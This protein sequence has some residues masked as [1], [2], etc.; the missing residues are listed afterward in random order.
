M[1]KARKLITFILVT[2]MVLSMSMTAW[3]TDITITGGAEG[4]VYSAY[5]LLNATDGGDGK[6]SYTLTEN[7]S[8]KSILQEVTGQTEEDDIIAYIAAQDEPE[9]TRAFADAVYTKIKNVQPAISADFTETAIEEQGVNKATFTG[10]AQGYYLIAEITTGSW[11]ED[12][13]SDTHSLVMLDTAGQENIE[14]A[15]KEER[16][17]LDKKIVADNNSVDGDIAEDKKSNNMSVGSKV[18]YTLTAT[19]PADAAQYDYY[20]CIFSDKLSE[21]LT[22]VNSGSNLLTV[23]A[24]GATEPTYQLYTG[25]DSNDKTRY[26]DG[27][28][29]Q[30]ALTNAK[31]LAGQTVTVT[32]WAELN[33]NAVVGD[34]TG[35]SNT[36]DLTYSNDPNTQYGETQG[37]GTPGKPDSTKNVPTGETPSEITTTYTTGIKILKTDGENSL[38][39]AEF[40]ITGNNVVVTLVS[41]AV[42]TED[43]VNGTYYLLKDGTYTSQAP[44]LNDEYVAAGLGATTG[45]VNTGTEQDPVWVEYDSSNPTHEELVVYIKKEANGDL[46]QS[47]STKYVKSTEFV[48]EGVG[49]SEPEVKAFV[50]ADGILYFEGLGEGTYTITETTVPAGYNKISDLTVTI[51]W[52]ESAPM[53]T[54]TVT[55]AEGN[56]SLNYIEENGVGVIELPIVNQAGSE[57]PST[58]GMGTT[59]FYIVG[60]ALVLIAVVLLITKKRMKSEK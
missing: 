58:G 40:Q 12:S 45:W 9:E 23:T 49:Q 4:S 57:L 59:L 43:D 2:V 11:G 33:E 32:Y 29:F 3:A 25:T 52:N 53:W 5:K 31:E 16:P 56:N 48:K 46:Y 44:Q 20:Y 50:D 1:K 19:I 60:G 8:I 6:F 15:T 7:E 55:P 39:G 47:T 24:S 51:T 34:D 14:V 41:R 22:F 27:N 30:V 35:N 54:A 10:L 13:T 38:S 36:A 37:D 21:G 17:T 28:T 18:Q 26:A 42:F